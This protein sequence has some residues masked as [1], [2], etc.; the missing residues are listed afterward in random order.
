MD[1]GTH[2]DEEAQERPVRAAE[3]SN[4]L[5]LLGEL[6]RKFA[7][8]RKWEDYHNPRSLILALMGELGE[9]AA[10]FRW[11]TDGEASELMQ[12]PELAEKVREE[13]ADVFWFLLRL[14]DVTGVNLGEA[15]EAKA[16]LNEERYPADQ[17]WGNNLKYTELPGN[18]N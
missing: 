14:A 18:R 1:N 8:A 7:Q 4:D 6:I 16:K 10:L 13:L 15:L 17:A 9:L 3:R 11:H 5:A 12:A 2:R